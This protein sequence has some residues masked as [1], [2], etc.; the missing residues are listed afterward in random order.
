MNKINTDQLH[1]LTK[2]FMEYGWSLTLRKNSIV[3][4]NKKFPAMRMLIRHTNWSDDIFTLS[5]YFEIK[6]KKGGYSYYNSK[7]VNNIDKLRDAL[8]HFNEKLPTNDIKKNNEIIPGRFYYSEWITYGLSYDRKFHEHTKN[9]YVVSSSAI[10][11][12]TCVKLIIIDKLNTISD[13][14]C[15]PNSAVHFLMKA[16][17]SEGGIVD[18]VLMN[19]MESYYMIKKCLRNGQKRLCIESPSIS[20]NFNQFDKTMCIEAA[21]LFMEANS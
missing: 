16:R 14:I 7:F 19:T 1:T 10:H 15:R 3:G 11:A 21:R 5:L 17:L 13:E 8:E 9:G 2:L 18:F 20:F 4:R 12:V 6:T